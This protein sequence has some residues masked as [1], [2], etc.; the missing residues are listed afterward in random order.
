MMNDI[1][2]LYNEVGDKWICHTPQLL[3]TVQLGRVCHYTLTARGKMA[4]TMPPGDRK[5]R[6][7]KAIAAL[8]S[9]RIE[10]AILNNGRSETTLYQKD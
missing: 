4:N 2:M 10:Q 3:D 7:I 9:G 1:R 5:E 6:V 8:R